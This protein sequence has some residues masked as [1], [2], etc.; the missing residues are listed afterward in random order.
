MVTTILC[1]IVHRLAQ[2]DNKTS[3]NPRL[4]PVMEDI[5]CIMNTDPLLG[6][7]KYLVTLFRGCI[8]VGASPQRIKPLMQLLKKNS[9]LNSLGKN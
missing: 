3:D 5:F 9:T 7:F 1:R 2:N 8:P 6:P 4:V